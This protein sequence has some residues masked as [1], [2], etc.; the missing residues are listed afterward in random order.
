MFRSLLVPLDG[1]PDAAAALPMARKIAQVT[2]GSITLLRVPLSHAAA[3]CQ[4]ATNYLEAQAQEL[5]RAGLTVHTVC[6]PGEPAREILAVAAP[7]P[8]I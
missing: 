5:R 2:G 8:A 7:E 4:K 6:R 3:D 1:S